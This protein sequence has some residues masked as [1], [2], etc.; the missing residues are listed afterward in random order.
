M[1]QAIYILAAGGDRRF[2]LLSRR[3]AARN[4][5]RVMTYGQGRTAYE[6]PIHRLQRISELK[7]APDI[8]VLPLPLTEDGE[9]LSMPLE[10]DAPPVRLTHLLDLCHPHTRVFCGITPAAEGFKQECRRRGLRL[11]D[12]MEDEGYALLNADATAEAAAALAVNLLPVTVRGLPVL[13]TGGGRIARS[14]TRLLSA[15]DADVTLC[16]RNGAERV[17]AA[18]L[19]ARTAPLD[20]LSEQLPG[21]MLICNTIPAPIFGR[22]EIGRISPDALTLELASSPGGFDREALEEAAFPLVRA[23]S[24]PGKTAPASC[25]A[26]LEDIVIRND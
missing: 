13:I 25:A 10:Q 8:L 9:T 2:V 20:A 23:L 19:G 5:T 7:S 24:L 26:W 14:L 21:K 17:T 6:E 22:E 16:A 11:I 3:L 12:Y 18:L 1:K 4:N 15:M